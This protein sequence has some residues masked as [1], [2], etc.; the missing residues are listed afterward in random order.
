MI[1][2]AMAVRVR[3]CVEEAFGDIVAFI[4]ADCIAD[5]RYI[6]SIVIAFSNNNIVAQAGE[7]Y[8]IGSLDDLLHVKEANKHGKERS[9]LLDLATT[10]NFAFRRELV[11]FVGNF[12]PWF[13]EGGEDYD[14]CFRLRKKGFTI[15]RNSHARVYHFASRPSLRKIW[16]GGIAMAKLFVRHRYA[17]N[18]VFIKLFHVITLAGSLILLMD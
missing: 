2:P 9:E 6:E 1:S 16:K 14:F 8:E 3:K 5:E 13:S 4:D 18:R 7:T 17:D 12:D 11:T 15:V 10:Q